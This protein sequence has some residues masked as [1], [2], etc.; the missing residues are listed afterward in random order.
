M[1]IEAD[2]AEISISRQCELMGLPRSSLY[3]RSCR[4]DRRDEEL[5][6]LLDEQYLRTPF[7]GVDRSSGDTIL[8]SA[9]CASS[10]VSGRAS[11][12]QDHARSSGRPS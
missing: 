5:M 3:Y 2:N 9:I 8:I 4:D 10:W 1:A 7:Y 6:R 12:A 11:L